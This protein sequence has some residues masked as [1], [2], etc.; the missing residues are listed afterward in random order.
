MKDTGLNSP[1]WP[2]LRISIAIEDLRKLY[3]E[4]AERTVADARRRRGIDG[5]PSAGFSQLYAEAVDRLAQ[6]KESTVNL[7]QN[8]LLA[9]IATYS[10]ELNMMIEARSSGAGHYRDENGS[11]LKG[12]VQAHVA[13]IAQLSAELA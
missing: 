4:Q 10:R 12:L 6:P 2:P 11:G 3:A 8:E 1:L 9:L 13:R 5:E 7:K